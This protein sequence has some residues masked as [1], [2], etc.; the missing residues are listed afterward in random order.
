[1]VYPDPLNLATPADTDLRGQGDDRIREMK[2]ALSQRF[3]TIFT[4]LDADPLAFIPGVIS[5]AALADG[6]INLAKLAA[7]S[8]D[9]SKLVDGAVTT[10]KIVDG[11]VT[12]AKLAA[13]VTTP[14]AGS[15]G[16]AELA[17]L[18]VT[19]PKLADLAVTSAKLADGSV[20]PAKIA[21]GGAFPYDQLAPAPDQTDIVVLVPVQ[22]FVAVN[23]AYTPREE[24]ADGGHGNPDVDGFQQLVYGLSLRPGVT[25]KRV[26]FYVYR[27]AGTDGWITAKVRK[28]SIPGGATV[29]LASIVADNTI[30]NYGYIDFAAINEIITAVSFY[31]LYVQLNMHSVTGNTTRLLYAELTLDWTNID[32]LFTL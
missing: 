17:D 2:R 31:S 4:D 23:L 14:A 29:D 6:A 24:N 25:I 21:A 27:A 18:S 19:T 32:Q 15:I 30:A 9:T 1:M 3:L 26:R 5:T 16:T 12:A 11:A 20:T 10:P 22:S 28:H 8:V 13:G 7:D